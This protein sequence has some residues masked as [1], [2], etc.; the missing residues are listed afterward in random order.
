MKMKAKTQ[1][2]LT[3]MFSHRSPGQVNVKE[4]VKEHLWDLHFSEFGRYI[5]QKFLLCLGAVY[6]GEKLASITLL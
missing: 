3:K 4:P 6:S 1:S 5:E 2:P